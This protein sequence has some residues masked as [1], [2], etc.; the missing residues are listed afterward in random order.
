[1][2]SFVRC[3]RNS[4][5]A[6]IRSVGSQSGSYRTSAQL[7]HNN[8]FFSRRSKHQQQIE[9]GDNHLLSTRLSSSSSNNFYGELD[10]FKALSNNLDSNI[11]SRL[12][13]IGITRPSAVQASSFDAISNG[14]DVILGAETGSG[15][16]L[17]YLLPLLFDIESKRDFQYCRSIILVPN[18]EL[19]NQVVRMCNEVFPSVKIDVMPGGLRN[20]EDYRPFRIL[21]SDADSSNRIDV[22]ITTPANLAP[23]ALSPKN[24]DFFADVQTLV[25]DEADMLLDGGFLQSLNSVLMGFRRADRLDPTHE[26]PKTQYVFV[27]ATLPD[28]GLKSVDAFIQKRFPEA[29][30]LRMA[31]MHNARHYGLKDRTTWIA[32]E[33][34]KVRLN[35][36]VDLFHED[37]IKNKEKVMIFLNSVEDVEGAAGALRRAGI[38][39]LPYHAKLKLGDRVANLGEF[40]NHSFEKNENVEDFEDMPVLVCTDLASRGLDLPGV[41]VVVQL[42][43]ATNVVAHLHRMGRAGRAGNVDGRGFIF[44]SEEGTEKALVDVIRDAETN[45]DAMQIEGDVDDPE[46]QSATVNKAFSR[47]RGFNKKRRKIS[48]NER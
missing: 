16:T 45:Q 48:S 39:A 14:E 20:P 30:R 41:T 26:V 22:C 29:K 43:F 10:G 28:F 33:N 5:A 27:A 1:M 24:I 18:K 46:E 44:Y 37:F 36:L 7:S 32:E 15:K 9:L 21:E 23:F 35:K 2:I 38:N 17:A 34:N 47:K 3:S 42:Q 40:R 13:D 31:G 8:F 12:D 11:I 6:F 25:I 4:A 19:S